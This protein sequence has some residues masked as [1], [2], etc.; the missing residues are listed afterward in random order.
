MARAAESS[1]R[2]CKLPQQSLAPQRALLS[3]LPVPVVV[4]I[5]LLAYAIPR[6]QAHHTRAECRAPPVL[7]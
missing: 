3:V 1:C 5:L 2:W 7:S 6:P 4:G